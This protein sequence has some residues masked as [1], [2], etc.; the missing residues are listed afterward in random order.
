MSRVIGFAT[1]VVL[2]A[3]CS[4]SSPADEPKARRY[5]VCASNERS[6][7]VTV[8][9]GADR[10][11]ITTIPVGKRPRGI[12]PSPD[13]K[14]LYVALSGSP[15][16]GPPKLD[17]KGRP[18]FPEEN[19]DKGDRSADGIGVIDL[20]LKKFLRKLP[21]GSDPEE[22]AVSKDGKR[23]YASNE[24]VATASVVSVAD[25]RVEQV[26]RVK[27]EPEGVAL[28][29]DGRSVYVTCETNGE[30]VVIDTKTN[31]AVAEIPVGGRPRTVAFSPDGSRAFIPSETAGTVSV[32]DTAAHKVL[33][34]I[35]LPEGSR[36]MGTVMSADGARLYVST[37][38]AGT[39]CVIDPAAGEVLQTIP[40]GKR[41]WGLGLSPDGKLLYVANGP[42][43]DVSVVDVRAAK[44]IGRVNAGKGPWGVAVVPA[45]E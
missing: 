19:P 10:R 21:A 24:D 3:A 4:A 40:V 11:V 6:G 33:H 29:P 39:V 37:G 15:I 44:E 7:D 23:L 27:K 35:K 1:A 14:S 2:A 16:L 18:I 32:V 26:V 41:P 5:W 8:I 25:G 38:R 34:A 43:D 36:P 12:H 28:T 17:A 42:S 31:K 13:G 22:F 45:P 20:K 9:D 30:V